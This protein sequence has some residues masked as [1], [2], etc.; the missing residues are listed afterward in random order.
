MDGTTA[1]ELRGARSPVAAVAILTRRPTDCFAIVYPGR[2][3]FPGGDGELITLLPSSLVSSFHRGWIVPCLRFARAAAR[4]H[5]DRLRRWRD[6][7]FEGP[8]GRSPG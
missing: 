4:W 8:F 6:A 5:C 2:A 7:M 3:L 1:C